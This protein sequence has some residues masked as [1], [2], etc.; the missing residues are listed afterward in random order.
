[1]SN[2]DQLKENLAIFEQ[3]DLEPG[4]LSPEEQKIIN[5]DREAYESIVTIPC[6]ACNYCMP[7][8]QRV[9]ISN[10]FNLYNDGHRFEFFDQV[11]RSYMF[12]SRGGSGADK[13]TN[14]GE[15]VPKCP[16]NI[17]IPKDLQT[18]HNTLKGWDE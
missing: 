9:G 7:C 14:C 17:D 13:C 16:Q 5:A 3:T 8:P 1:M 6:T 4:C 10:I 11:R 2:M 18:A 12:A 15:C